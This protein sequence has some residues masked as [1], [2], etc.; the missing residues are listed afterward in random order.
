MDALSCRTCL[1]IVLAKMQFTASGSRETGGR[2]LTVSNICSDQVEMIRSSFTE[3]AMSCTNE[4]VS[5]AYDQHRWDLPIGRH[6]VVEDGVTEQ[7]FGGFE[8]GIIDY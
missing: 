7:I 1:L 2:G 5:I 8:W 3:S 4:N 6:D